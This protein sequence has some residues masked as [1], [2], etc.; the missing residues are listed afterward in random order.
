VVKTENGLFDPASL[1]FPTP[2][3][4]L[5]SVDEDQRQ[6]YFLALKFG[7]YQIIPS[8]STDIIFTETIFSIILS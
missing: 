2:P 3:R 7:Q 1:F 5:I 6:K 4:K 8:P